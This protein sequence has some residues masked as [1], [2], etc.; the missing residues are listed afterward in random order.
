V[1][2]SVEKYI[3]IKAIVN[4]Y[5]LIKIKEGTPLLA[6]RAMVKDLTI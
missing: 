6:N 1:N 5:F 2:T 3:G 4:I